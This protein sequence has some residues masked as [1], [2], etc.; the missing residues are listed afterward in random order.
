MSAVAEVSIQLLDNCPLT[1]TRKGKAGKDYLACQ[2]SIL[3]ATI[4][5]DTT[6]STTV[7]VVTLKFC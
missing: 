7:F 6:S 1:A 5:L 4:V 3:P 2:P